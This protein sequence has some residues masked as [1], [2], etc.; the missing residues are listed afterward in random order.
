MRL[1]LLPFALLAA[2]PLAAR[3][4]DDAARCA[5]PLERIA[6]IGA[7]VSLGFEVL[8]EHGGEARLDVFLRALLRCRPEAVTLHANAFM[9]VQLAAVGPRMVREA[10]AT[11]P[12]LVVALDF[13]FWYAYGDRLVEESRLST[14][15]QGLALLDEFPCPVLI[16]DVPDMT[17]ALAGESSIGPMLLESQVPRPE[18]LQRVNERLRAWAAERPRMIVVPMADFIDRMRA[19]EP[20][21]LRG[22]HWDAD[23]VEDFLQPDLL[24]PTAEGTIALCLLALDRLASAREDV[25]DSAVLWDGDAVLARVEEAL[26]RMDAR[27][28]PASGS[29]ADPAKHGGDGRTPAPP[30]EET[31]CSSRTRTRAVSA[32]SSSR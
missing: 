9:F 3:S 24:H 11:E 25:L 26:D 22:N 21:A 17:P 13:L 31:Q 8:P 16:G 28:V 29:T 2:S 30:E 32:W 27:E 14:F 5:P 7:S 10:K 4:D 23:D 12:T 15:E 19:G 20:I 6:V 1:G 18:T